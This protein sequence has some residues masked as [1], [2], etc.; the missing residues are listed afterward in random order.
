MAARAVL[1][2]QS[3]HEISRPAS[4]KGSVLGKNQEKSIKLVKKIER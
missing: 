4:T 1:R 3:T 2:Y